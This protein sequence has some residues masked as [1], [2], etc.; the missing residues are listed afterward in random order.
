VVAVGL[1]LQERLVD[2]QE[3]L[4]RADTLLPHRAVGGSAEHLDAERQR[5]GGGGDDPRTGRFGDHRGLTDVSATQRRE[6]AEPAVLLADDAVHCQGPLE[7][8]ARVAQR[9]HHRQVRGG[10]GLHVARAAPEQRPVPDLRGE[11][12]RA[13]PVV[14]VAGGYDVEVS[15]QHQRRHALAGLAGQRADHADSRL[16][17]HLDPGKPRVLDELREVEVPAVH[18]RVEV[19]KH[20]RGNLLDLD[21][22]VGAAHARDAHQLH[23][24]LDQRVLVE[25][26]QHGALGGGRLVGVGAHG[27]SVPHPVGSRAA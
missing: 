10:T 24:R 20:R 23:E 26:V 4:E 15:L 9:A 5:T 16:A 12:V 14:R 6:T 1:E 13:E 22:G 21:L 3:R 19:A 8:H 17:V 25:V 18:V 11:R 2:R 27:P 7:S